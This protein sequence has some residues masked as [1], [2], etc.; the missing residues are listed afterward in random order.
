MCIRTRM[1]PEYGTARFRP[2][3]PD[4]DPDPDPYSTLTLILT[5]TLMLTHGCARVEYIIKILGLQRC[6]DTVV[7]NAMVRTFWM[8]PLC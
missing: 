7:G 8:L 1:M 6:A 2:M 4:P 5:L 3:I